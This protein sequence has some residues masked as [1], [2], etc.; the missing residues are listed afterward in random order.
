MFREDSRGL[1]QC[2][3]FLEW[4]WLD[5]GFSTRHSAGWLEALPLASL[6]QVHGDA[7]LLATDPGLQGEADALIT[8]TPELHIAVRTADCLPIL[9][10]DPVQRAVAAVHAGW[11]GTV[12]EIAVKTTARMAEELGTKPEDL[13]AAIGPGIGACCFEVGPE[14]AEQFGRQGRVHIHLAGE[15]VR[16]LAAAG[17]K[18][19]NIR[20]ATHCTVCRPELFWSYRREREAA[21]RMWSG[22]ALRR[23]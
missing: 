12:A 7:V 2:E 13:H 22:V 18:P 8:R 1:L 6:K 10:V 23:Q 16:Q 14:V 19:D 4:P 3:R 21:G 20:T 17:L 5:H 11:R 9:L 15:I